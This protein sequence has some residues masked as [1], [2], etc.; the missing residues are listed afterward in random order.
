MK[1]IGGVRSLSESEKCITLAWVDCIGECSSDQLLRNP[2]A[3]MYGISWEDG[4][5]ILG[6][7]RGR[8]IIESAENKSPN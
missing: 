7:D 3:W 6:Y 2:W 5:Q 4:G 8:Y 1:T